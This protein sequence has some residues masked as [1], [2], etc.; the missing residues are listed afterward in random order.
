MTSKINEAINNRLLIVEKRLEEI[1]QK[2]A[3][4]DTAKNSELIKSLYIE[5]SEIAPLVALMRNWRAAVA[6]LTEAQELVNDPELAELAQEE[7]QV[8]QVAVKKAEQALLSGLV[9]QDT[10]D[11]KN[12]F[13]E[14]R[15][16]TGGSESGLFAGDLLRMY[17]RWAENNHLKLSIVSSSP[18]EIGGYKEVIAQIEGNNAYRFF[19]HEAG[20]HRVQ[21]IPETESQGRIHTSVCTVAVMPKVQAETVGINA[22]DLRIDTF[23]SSGA[24]G[25]HVNTT[26]SAVRITHLPTNIIAESQNDRSQHRNKEKA[27]EMLVARVG[28]HFQKIKDAEQRDQRRKMVGSGERH[29]KIRTYNFPQG[30]VTDHRIPLTLRRLKEIMEG[31]LVEFHNALLQ[32]E[33]AERITMAV[34]V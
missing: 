28:S 30:R 5:R 18:G 23:R 15:A 9:P 4:Q 10:S 6:K 22:S 11:N 32:A 25:Q 34:Q 8:A 12:T 7:Q 13:L 20:A 14:I 27:M 24:G 16:G 19:K 1:E 21:R 29:E 31:D 26:D 2:L 17:T 33:E 3:H